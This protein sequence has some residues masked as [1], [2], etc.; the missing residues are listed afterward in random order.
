M[1]YERPLI[2]PELETHLRFFIVSQ[3]KCVFLC[4]AIELEA[5][6]PR[7]TVLQFLWRLSVSSEDA[8][9]LRVN[10]DGMPPS[11]RV[12]GDTPDFSHALTRVRVNAVEM[13][14]ELPID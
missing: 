12:V 4:K 10:V 3:Q 2:V 14:C 6:Y 7:A 9:V 8:E 13:A 1:E 5:G 11:T